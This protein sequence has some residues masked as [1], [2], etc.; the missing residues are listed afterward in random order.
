MII[1]TLVDVL[2]E[3]EEDLARVENTVNDDLYH[4]E[5]SHKEVLTQVRRAQRNVL[6]AKRAARRVLRTE[7]NA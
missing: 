4:D 6:M 2:G 1:T 5:P 7:D 3:I